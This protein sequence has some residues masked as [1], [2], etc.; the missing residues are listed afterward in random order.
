[1]IEH[2]YIDIELIEIL[3]NNPRTIEESSLKKLCL[4]IEADPTFLEQRPS[5]INFKDGKYICYAGQQRIK[6]QKLLG[7]TTAPVFI[8]ND[9][10]EEVQNRRMVIDNTHRGEWDMKMLVDGFNFSMDELKDFGFSLPEINA[11]F[12]EL[13]ADFNKAEDD[14]FEIPEEIETDIKVGDV[15]RI[16]PHILVCGDST[17]ESTYHMLMSGSLA[18]LVVTDPPYNVNYEGG[19]KDALTI[20]NDS[21][22]DQE[23][24][25]FLFNF[26]S[27]LNPF[28]KE[29]AA[30]YVWH[31]DSEGANFRLAMKNAGI[32]VKQCLIWVKNSMVMGRQD[33]QWKHEPC[34][35]G[36]KPGAAHNWYSDRKQTTILEFD[37]PIRNA[38]H[39]TMKPVE[40]ISYQ[41]KNSSKVGDI[42]VDAFGGSGTTMVVC[43]QMKRNARL[44]EFDPKYCQVIIDRMLKLDSSLEVEKIAAFE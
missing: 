6:A 37:K 14:G 35:Y 3:E 30:W 40:L 15:F 9:V 23:F 29:G 41:V 38:E 27:S 44:I 18:D 2:K 22:S 42:V 28:V 11:G 7:R 19:T 26:Y 13:S 32:E 25:S 34:L 43:H 36:W 24:Y 8:E 17:I 33:Y 10:P 4:D 1:M 31:A 5:L 39:P 12:A 20:M 21:M 16:G